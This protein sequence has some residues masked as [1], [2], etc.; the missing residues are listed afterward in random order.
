MNIRGYLTEILMCQN[1]V[2]IEGVA[3]QM[4]ALL[5]GHGDQWITFKG[6]FLESMLGAIDLNAAAFGAVYSFGLFG[7]VKTVSFNLL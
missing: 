4:S 6:L 3:A 5:C 7:K 1:I 2:A